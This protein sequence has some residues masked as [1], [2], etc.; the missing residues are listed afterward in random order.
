MV[1]FDIDI[2]DV[3]VWSC[4]VLLYETYDL[5]ATGKRASIVRSIFS[6]KHFT[7]ISLG[8]LTGLNYDVPAGLILEVRFVV[9]A[10]T[11]GHTPSLPSKTAF[12]VRPYLGPT[13]G[14]VT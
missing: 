8:T 7:K 14:K 4:I 12:L 5:C 10:S 13:T 3:Y 11:K 2:F 1:L 9:P 6:I